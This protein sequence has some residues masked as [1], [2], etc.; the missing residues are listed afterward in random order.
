MELRGR[1]RAGQGLHRI[2]IGSRCPNRFAMV[3]RENDFTEFHNLLRR[4]EI[5]FVRPRIL[6]LTDRRTVLPA[7]I[8]PSSVDATSIVVLKMLAGGV[9]HQIPGLL[10]H[11][12]RCRFMKQIP[13]DEIK[14]RVRQGCLNRQRKVMTALGATPGAQVRVGRQILPTWPGTSIRS[15][16]RR[17]CKRHCKL[18][19]SHP[20]CANSRFSGHC[21]VLAIAQ[22]QEDSFTCQAFRPPSS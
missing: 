14:I 12:Y 21:S 20:R 7:D 19:S 16:T 1:R 9:N 3:R 2:P 15:R 11:K 6:V 13:S 10:F 17:F 4:L 8:R 5:L 18:Q 22:Q